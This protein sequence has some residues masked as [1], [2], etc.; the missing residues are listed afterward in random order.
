VDR[1]RAQANITSALS[2]AGIAIGVFGLTFLVAIIY[3]G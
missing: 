1:T 3:I 2:T